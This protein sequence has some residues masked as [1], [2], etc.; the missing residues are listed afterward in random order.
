MSGN[1]FKNK[2][3]KRIAYNDYLKIMPEMNKIFLS[4]KPLGSAQ[5]LSK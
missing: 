5:R 1:A 2:E 4:T 3:I